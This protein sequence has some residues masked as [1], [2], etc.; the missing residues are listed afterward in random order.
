M[1]EGLHY[2]L[3]I[4]PPKEVDITK[5]QFDHLSY[6]GIAA[7]LI[8]F[9][10]VIEEQENGDYHIYGSVSKLYKFVELLYKELKCYDLTSIE[11]MKIVIPKDHKLYHRVNKYFPH[12]KLK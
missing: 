2:P 11:G 10:F 4:T 5:E 9:P 6:Y 3:Y 7:L 1:S 12:L 8:A